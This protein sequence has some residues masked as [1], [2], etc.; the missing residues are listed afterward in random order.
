MI[1]KILSIKD[2]GVFQNFNG[3]SLPELKTFNLIYGWNYSGKTTL[4]R[5]FRCLEQGKLHIDYPLAKFAFEDES[6]TRSDQ[7]FSPKPNIRVFNSDFVADNLKWD[8]DSIEPI[9]L[10]GEENIALQKEL[11]EKQEELIVLERELSQA[12][13]LKDNKQNSIK[14]ALTKKARDMTD[15]LGLGRSFRQDHLESLIKTIITDD[16]GKHTLN[17]VEFDKCKAQALSNEQKPPIDEVDFATVDLSELKDKVAMLLQRQAT[18]GQKI[19]KLLENKPISD[20]VETGKKLHEGKTECEFCG[21]TLPS[22]LFEKLNEHFSKDYEQLKLDIEALLEQLKK[23]KI[24][25]QSP[26]P[27]ETAFYADLQTEFKKKKPIFDS[28]V[29]LYN[30]SIDTLINDLE[31]KKE[32]PFDKLEVTIFADNSREIKGVLSVF[33]DCISQNNTRT[34]RFEADKNTAIG[35]LKAHFAADFA[36]T[37]KYSEVQNELSKEMR[38][39]DARQATITKK[40]G[41]IADIKAQLNETV[42]G[43]KKV[44][45]YLNI[46]FGKDDVKIESTSDNRFKLMRGSNIAKNLSEGEKTA[47]SFAYFIAKLEEQNNQMLNT[48]VYIDDPVSSLDSN[49]L[50]NIYAFIKSTFYEFDPIAPDKHKAKCKQLFISTHNFDFHNLIFDWFKPRNIGKGKQTFLMVERHKNAYKDESIVKANN[51]LLTLFNSEYAY[52]FS[53]LHSFQETPVDTCEFLYHLPNIARR[54]V[55]TYLNFKYLSPAN[56]EESIDQLVLNP[57]ECER[58]RKFMH[59]FSHSLTTDKF[60]RLPDLAECQAVIGI[61][62]KSV[63]QNDPVHFAS[64]KKALTP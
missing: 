58:S 32:K 53:L 33:N 11:K 22:D 43:A 2:F 26:L 31:Y 27:T 19:Q 52:L 18:T 62:L 48:I 59:Y 8:S 20:W 60:M 21:N 1:T 3:V 29:S 37:E 25:L 41:Q 44:D 61:I 45:E 12:K 40:S 30:G 24:V 49:H 47:I 34:I 9:F 55:E 14:D 15:I 57:V 64:L 23:T 36:S 56:I 16:A 46:F 5:V 35:K 17:Q 7:T 54:F 42:K 63:E 39:I 4:S 28:S 50:F 6:G 51:N 38:D 10:L 13:T